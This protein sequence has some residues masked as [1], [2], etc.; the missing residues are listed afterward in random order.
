MI[1]S[2]LPSNATNKNVTWS[3][4][5]GSGTASLSGSGLLTALTNGTGTIYATAQDGSAV[6]GSLGVVISN[7]L[8]PTLLTGLV[9]Y[10]NL[11]EASGTLYDSQS[12]NHFDV[13]Y[14]TPTY[15]TTGKISYGVNFASAGDGAN[16]MTTGLNATSAASLSLWVK[17]NQLPTTSGHAQ[18]IFRNTHTGAPWYSF[19]LNLESN[20]TWLFSVNDINGQVYNVVHSAPVINTWYHVVCVASQGSVLKLYIN[21]VKTSSGGILVSNLISTDEQSSIGNAYENDSHGAMAVIDEVAWGNRAFTDADVALLYNSGNGLTWPFAGT[22]TA[23]SITTT[24]A[25]AVTNNGAL[26]GGNVTSNGGDANAYAGVVIA[27]FP[28]PTLTSYQVATYSYYINQQTN[29][30]TVSISGLLNP[31]TTYY[32][33]GYIA[34]NA[35]IT[36]GSEYSLVTLGYP[37]NVYYK[38]NGSFVKSGSSF[39]ITH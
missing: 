35:G 25:T 22:I 24:L 10:Y 7:Q 23:G 6:S 20:N 4:V 26:F 29:P 28:S 30:F 37:K 13:V 15:H 14:G 12:T 36:Y 9:S 21:N 3:W 27:D 1:A 17:F 11:D 16:L 34:N 18:Y 19:S 8:P 33:R 5:N 39:Y 2:V 38:C 31:L 32:Y